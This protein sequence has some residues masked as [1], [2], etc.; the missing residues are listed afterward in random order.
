MVESKE[1]EKVSSEEEEV[2]IIEVSE[3]EAEGAEER[4][5]TRDVYAKKEFWDDRFKE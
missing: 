2:E 3:E 4:V 5:Y 1:I